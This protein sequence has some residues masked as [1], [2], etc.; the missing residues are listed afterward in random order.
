MTVANV[1]ITDTRWLSIFYLVGFC[2]T[3]D[4]MLESR[5]NRH[6]IEGCTADLSGA[7]GRS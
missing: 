2:Y 1:F 5:M 3:I 4:K 7:C 6:M